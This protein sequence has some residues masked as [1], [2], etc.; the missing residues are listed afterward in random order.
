MIEYGQ[1]PL[2]KRGI[3]NEDFRVF[4]L[5][6]RITKDV[7]YH[8][9]DFHKIII[10][11]K[12]NVTY[13]I[14]GKAYKLR[15]WDTLIIS[16]SQIHKP[17]ID[18]SEDYERIIIWFNPEM[19]A[20]HNREDANLLECFEVAMNRDN[21]RL[22][23]FEEQLRKVKRIVNDFLEEEDSPA[24]GNDILKRTL[25]I[26][27]IILLN[28]SI[29]DINRRN[30]SIDVQF[31]QNINEIV[32]Y[33]NQHLDGDLSVGHLASLVFLSKY[34]LMRKFKAYTGYT[35]HQYIVQKR[36]MYAKALM[37]EGLRLTDVCQSAGFND[38]SGFVRAFKK[39][40]GISPREY[41]K[42]KKTV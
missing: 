28:R 21:N 18:P 27:L 19:I 22:R 40:F 17:I 7:D 24:F 8:Y 33:I 30:P 13:M 36:L 4:H 15:P 5:K 39:E 11:L 2:E 3:L 1:W 16:Q 23:L 6:D 34:H 38:Y 35:L 14:E 41:L 31:D 20:E 32:T 42:V 9:H 10:F 29:L 12:G 26:Q 37:A 25:L